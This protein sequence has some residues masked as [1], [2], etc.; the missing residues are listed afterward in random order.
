M[1]DLLLC[2]KQLGKAFIQFTVNIL[3]IR[4]EVFQ[5]KILNHTSHNHDSMVANSFNN[6]LFAGNNTSVH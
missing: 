6:N 4:I 1:G 3:I 2:L 5:F